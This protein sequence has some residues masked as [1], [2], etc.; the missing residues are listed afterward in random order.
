MWLA[1]PI[2]WRRWVQQ[3]EGVVYHFN[4]ERILLCLYTADTETE[5]F[6]RMCERCDGWEFSAFCIAFM[7]VTPK[8]KSPVTD[9]SGFSLDWQ[10]FLTVYVFILWKGIHTKEHCSSR[11]CSMYMHTSDKKSYVAVFHLFSHKTKFHHVCVLPIVYIYHSKYLL[12]NLTSFTWVL[13][14]LNNLINLNGDGV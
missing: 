12:Y 11:Y 13:E 8:I 1:E 10:G 9:V 7:W 3:Y 4:A 14:Q 6:M 2:G 5:W